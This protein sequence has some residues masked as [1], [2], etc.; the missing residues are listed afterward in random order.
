MPWLMQM[1]TPTVAICISLSY[2][3]VPEFWVPCHACAWHHS[4]KGLVPLAL[5]SLFG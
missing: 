1:A 5:G 2:G 3:L 4:I